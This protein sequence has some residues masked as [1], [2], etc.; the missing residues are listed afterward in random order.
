MRS[1]VELTCVVVGTTYR[2]I[3]RLEL[4]V[5]TDHTFCCEEFVIYVVLHQ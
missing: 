1:G 4:L 2:L 5:G 3:M